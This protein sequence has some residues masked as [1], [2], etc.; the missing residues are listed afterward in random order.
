[1]K[2]QK[3]LNGQFSNILWTNEDH[4]HKLITMEILVKVKS[5]AAYKTAVK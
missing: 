1:M 5:N 2:S 4:A 3:P